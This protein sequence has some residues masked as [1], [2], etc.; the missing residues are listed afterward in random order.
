MIRAA[1]DIHVIGQRATGN[2]TYAEGLLRAF[3]AT[4]P[5]D[6]ELLYYHSR[7][8]AHGFERGR[9]RRMWPD[10]PYVRIPLTTPYFLARD[11]VD[12]AH[13]QY[14]APPLCPCATVLT[15]HDLS[16]ER[17]PEYFSRAM[18]ARMRALMPWMAR[19]ATRL[20]AVSE[21][22][23][24]DLTQ[25][26]GIDPA[27]IDVIHNGISPEFGMHGDREALRASLGRFALAGPFIVCVGNLGRRKN[28]ARVVRAFSRLV[29]ERG[30]PHTLVLIGK[31]EQM[32]TEVLAEIDRGGAAARIRIAGFV[33]R[34]ELVALYRL[35]EFSVYAS[36]Y[37]GFGL[38]IVESM[39][40]A[41]PVVTSSA[42][43]MPEI[44]GEAALYADPAD[45]ASVFAAM[46]RMAHDESLRRR[47]GD[48][49]RERS[50]RF[51]WAEAAR[52]T[53]ESYRL[54]A[55]A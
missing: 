28:Q 27:R 19:R 51:S 45:D 49:G 8:D 6:V 21:A 12:V 14:F 16:F 33:S 10:W 7:P 43:C 18:A 39:A 31:Q 50:L 47:L 23:R 37:E 22:T 1:F 32:A 29:R 42:S 53:L 38:P 30:V 15:V 13:F 54:A 55:G 24:A 40:C 46:D 2:E 17:H 4:P 11:R 5:G 9:H 44:A 52:R 26:Y 35:A 3:D 41:T 34:E 48:A 20:I 25:L 36:H